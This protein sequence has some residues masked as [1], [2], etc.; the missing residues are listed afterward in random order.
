[1]NDSEINV[2]YS[3]D[4]NYAQHMG[5]S[6]WSL[7][8]QNQDFKII[9]IYIIDNHISMNNKAKIEQIVKAFSG[10]KIVW[11]PFKKYEEK[12][13]LDMPWSISI[14]AY[15]R[16][17]IEQMLPETMNRVIYLDCDTV[18][19]DSLHQLWQFNLN[20]KTVGVV[21]DTV[22]ATAKEKLGISNEDKYFN[23]GMLLIDLDAWRAK[24]I[25]KKCLELIENYNGNVCHHDQGVLNGVFK[26]DKC[27]LPMRYNTITVHYF[28][29]LY[30]IRKYY[31][32]YA[33]FYSE[34]EIEE[35]KR[36]PAILHFTPSFT[37]RPWIKGCQHPL[38]QKYWDVLKKTPWSEAK[39]QKNTAK[40]HVRLLEW[41]YR[42][43]PF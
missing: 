3:S 37:S 26:E 36:A 7:V 12:L 11:I 4:N 18:I 23:S 21:Q 31:E 40:W 15:A 5:V 17:F 6:I 16:L 30:Q 33:P 38:R 20:G 10:V 13:K 19:C 22:G 43:L 25:S 35:A 34:Q 39:P 1:M 27:F 24:Q 8:E 42:V 41:R 2:I 29:N 14:S 28:F 32:E 9:N